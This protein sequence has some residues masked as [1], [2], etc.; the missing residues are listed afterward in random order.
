MIAIIPCGNT[1]SVINALKR[2]GASWLLAESTYAIQQNNTV[3]ALVLPGNGN[4]SA[5]MKF[6]SHN[7]W[8][9]FIK[10]WIS[11]DK[12]FLGIC[13]G[14]QVLFQGSEEGVNE[15]PAITL[16]QTEKI[17]KTEGNEQLVPGLGL[18]QGFVKKFLQTKV[19]LIGWNKTAFSRNSFFNAA[20]KS[21]RND[22]Q[23]CNNI[24]EYFYYI[25]SYYV[26]CINKADVMASASYGV[27][28]CAAVQRGALTGVQFHPEKS[29]I[30]G[31]AFL[32]AWMEVFH[33][34]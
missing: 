19:P 15:Q 13:I 6:L 1:G 34:R 7:G 27:D 29:G 32:N 25:H 20:Q 31:Q 12:P 16:K 14:F 24:M 10:T 5:V 3:S 21:E 23:G 26:D 22:N 30:A 11:A 18:L 2:L 33:A 9:D 17:L 4:F 28:Y 8:A